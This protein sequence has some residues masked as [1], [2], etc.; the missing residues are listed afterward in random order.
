MERQKHG[1]E[2]EKDVIQRFSLVKEGCYTGKWDAYY[3][4]IP[5]SIKYEKFGSDVEL[6]DYFRQTA[7]DKDFYNYFIPKYEVKS[8]EG[9][10]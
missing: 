3:K 5:V 8:L 6:A 10:D 9:D 7:I 4:D 2:Y 1:F